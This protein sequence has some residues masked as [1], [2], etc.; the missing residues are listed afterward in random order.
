MQYKYINYSRY[1]VDNIYAA[2]ENEKIEDFFRI[3]KALK[4]T[5]NPYPG[6]HKYLKEVKELNLWLSDRLTSQEKGIWEKILEESTYIN[7]LY[8]ELYSD[9]QYMVANT[10]ES[11]KELSAF[12]ICIEYILKAVLE[13]SKGDD[14]LCEQIGLFPNPKERIEDINDRIRFYGELFDNISIKIKDILEYICFVKKNRIICEKVNIDDVEDARGHVISILKKTCIDLIV[15]S[16]QFGDLNISLNQNIV[17]VRNDFWGRVIRLYWEIRERSNVTTW[18][19]ARNECQRE[20]NYEQIEIE[21]AKNIL[22]KQLFVSDINCQCKIFKG[23]KLDKI[24]DIFDFV[25]SYARLKSI[26]RDFLDTQT[27]T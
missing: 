8:E 26:C 19:L 15:E 9:P 4:F 5:I 20:Y 23:N 11:S 22:K 1:N 18:S 13:A 25:K 14:Y 21:I 16:W 27:N 10:I 12:L 2:Y 6:E 3:C 17:V 7:M 24:I